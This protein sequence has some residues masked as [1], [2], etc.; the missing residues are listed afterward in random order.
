MKRTS[1]T[2]RIREGVA[3]ILRIAIAGM[4]VASS[5][6][7]AAELEEVTVTA[8]KREQS[9]QDIPF[10]ITALGADSLRA[11]GV[12]SLEDI[13]SSVPGL[14][15][16]DQSNGRTQVNIRGIS[17]GEVRRDNTRAQ[18]TVGI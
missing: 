1:A 16:A 13:A 6:V 5:G 7:A 10:A 8:Q 12:A 17:S 4:L 2:C 11:N 9:V 15:V 18:E 3:H 14:T